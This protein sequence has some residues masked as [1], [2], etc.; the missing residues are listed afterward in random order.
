MKLK[1]MQHG[2][3]FTPMAFISTTGM[4][5]VEIETYG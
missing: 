1:I 2:N 4:R 5:H 3:L